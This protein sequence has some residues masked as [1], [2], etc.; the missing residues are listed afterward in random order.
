VLDSHY[1]DAQGGGYFKIADDG[2]TLIAREKSAYDGA[3]P[4]GNSVTTLNLLRLYEFTTDVTHLERANLLFASHYESL[5]RG[6]TGQAEMAIALD[7]Q[8]DTPKEIV[9]VSPASG[10]GLQEMLAPLRRTFLPN[11]SV[12]IVREG[13]ELE[14][15]ATLAPLVR[16]KK[17][18]RGATTAYVCEN[19]VCAF[20]TRSP[21][22]FQK[23][24]RQVR[25]LGP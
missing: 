19:R 11:K 14:R 12:S 23:Q 2:E 10:E 17:A 22:E 4:S 5:S 21:D 1:L 7:Y 15:H 16:G 24:L 25:T 3:I 8:L 6:S 20:P 18:R 9:I 13:A